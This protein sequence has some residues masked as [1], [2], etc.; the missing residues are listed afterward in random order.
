MKY[1]IC[2]YLK[3]TTNNFQK[4]CVYTHPLTNKDAWD[5][6]DNHQTVFSTDHKFTTKFTDHT[7]AAICC[8]ER[9]QEH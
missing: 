5:S 9:Q 8:E 4:E 1:S 7:K 3:I 6:N 2:V